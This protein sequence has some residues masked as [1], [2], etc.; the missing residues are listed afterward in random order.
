MGLC[1][2]KSRVHSSHGCPFLHQNGLK[3]AS[4]QL[5]PSISY[6]CPD[7]QNSR[8]L[9][10]GHRDTLGMAGALETDVHFISVVC[11]SAI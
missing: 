11:V 10:A 6:P 7:P 2:L 3:D 4:R 9:E 1:I 5:P 8:M